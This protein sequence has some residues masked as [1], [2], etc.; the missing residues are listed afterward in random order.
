M[1]I[2]FGL[3]G[4]LFRRVTFL[5]DK[6]LSLPSSFSAIKNCLCLKFRLLTHCNR[7]WSWVFSSRK[8]VCRG[9]FQKRHME[10]RVDLI[11][12]WKCQFKD[13]R[14]YHSLYLKKPNESWTQLLQRAREFQIS[15][16]QPDPLSNFQNW[17]P[18]PILI[19][20]PFIILLSF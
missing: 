20:V 1:N 12:P 5:F 13:L 4:I 16:I 7:C 14:I 8:M 17:V 9:R 6:I 3:P 19:I 2:S 15:R 11:R 10:D 18:P